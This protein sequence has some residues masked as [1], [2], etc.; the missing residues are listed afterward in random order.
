MG[1]KSAE[2]TMKKSGDH[3]RHAIYQTTHNVARDHGEDP[4]TSVV[5]RFYNLGRT[6]CVRMG[7]SVFREYRLQPFGL[8]VRGIL[9]AKA[10]RTAYLKKPS[11]WC[12]RESGVL[13]IKRPNELDCFRRAFRSLS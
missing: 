1:A 5:N 13:T 7:S 2:A 4:R 12:R 3:L 11:H 10:I 9:V 8:A 6:Q